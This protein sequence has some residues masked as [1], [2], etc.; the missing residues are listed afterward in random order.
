MVKKRIEILPFKLP[1]ECGDLT[2]GRV[3]VVPVGTP[4]ELL[5]DCKKKTGRVSSNVGKEKGKLFE[6][7]DPV[8]KE[9]STV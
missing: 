9:S 5:L 8:K 1:K 4:S 3:C 2:R 6:V 7:Y